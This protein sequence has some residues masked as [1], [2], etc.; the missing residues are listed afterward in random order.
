[1]Y[2]GTY[3]NTYT[4][5]YYKTFRITKTNLSFKKLYCNEWY[6]LFVGAG[7]DFVITVTLE[8]HCH[9]VSN[10]PRVLSYRISL[11]S[12]IKIWKLRKIDWRYFYLYSWLIIIRKRSFNEDHVK[13]YLLTGVLRAHPLYFLIKA[14]VTNFVLK[15]TPLVI[16]IRRRIANEKLCKILFSYSLAATRS[17]CF[18][19]K[20][21]T[22]YTSSPLSNLVLRSLI[23][24]HFSLLLFYS[25]QS[26][27][28]RNQA[29]LDTRL[30]DENVV[31]QKF[32]YARIYV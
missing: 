20:E 28:Y 11:V 14:V 2:V 27:I 30:H 5:G 31:K 23:L 4:Y 3:I 25:L 1:M 9:K 15:N 16:I 18:A 7:N 29:H 12:D 24:L 19:V 22:V 21:Y 8:L 13:Y 26:T 17:L 32:F 10:F 6:G